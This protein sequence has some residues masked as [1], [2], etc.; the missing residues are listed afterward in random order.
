MIADQEQNA[1]Q[2]LNNPRALGNAWIVDK[3][4]VVPS[5]DALLERVKT[6]DFLSEALVIDNA[7]PKELLMEY[8]KDS[9]TTIELVKSSPD[10]LVYE[11][12]SKSPQCAV[13]SEMYYPQGWSATVNGKNSPIVNV[14]YV[15]RGLE[16]PSGTSTVI[17]SFEPQVVIQGTRL[18]WGSLILFI[19][20]LGGIYFQQSRTKTLVA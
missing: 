14:N 11:I 10:N 12:E 18:R 2:P 15:L 17:F 20:I 3:V 4:K 6:T 19:L 8:D 7:Y 1:L 5:A 13:F 16:V 9:L